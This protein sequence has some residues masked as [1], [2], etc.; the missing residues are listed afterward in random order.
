MKAKDDEVKRRY[1]LSESLGLVREDDP[2]LDTEA[3]EGFHQAKRKL[4]IEEI[5]GRR[6]A[7]PPASSSKSSLSAT[8]LRNSLRRFD[9]FT[10]HN[11]PSRQTGKSLGV[12]VRK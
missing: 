2:G 3:K 9:P 5:N 4:Q 1:G 7:E 8:V 10:T 12:S 11:R 6:R